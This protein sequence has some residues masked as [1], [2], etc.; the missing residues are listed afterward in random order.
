[1]GAKLVAG[2]G[3]DG[4]FILGEDKE[5]GQVKDADNRYFRSGQA[6]ERKIEKG[7]KE[8]T[9]GRKTTTAIKQTGGEAHRAPRQ[10]VIATQIVRMKKSGRACNYVTRGDIHE[11]EVW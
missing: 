8:G 10:G 1:M 9:G 5:A 11:L 4:K 6:E 7:T 2:E 3:H